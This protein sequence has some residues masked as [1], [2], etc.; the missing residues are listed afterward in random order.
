MKS[1]K[2]EDLPK[3]L[4]GNLRIAPQM[5]GFHDEID[6]ESE[7]KGID[8]TQIHVQICV[9]KV[10]LSETQYISDLSMKVGQTEIV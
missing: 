2:S 8:P 4:Q 7:I 10:Q 5:Q 6:E 3:D 1:M 9:L